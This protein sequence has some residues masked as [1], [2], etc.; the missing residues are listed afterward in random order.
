MLLFLMLVAKSSA[1]L[2][3]VLVAGSTGIENYRHQADLC[4]S[5]HLLVDRMAVDPSQVTVMMYDDVAWSPMNPLIGR[6][7]NE[8]DGDNVYEGCLVNHRKET[9]TVDNF[10]AVLNNLAA[11]GNGTKNL[12]V[13]FVDHGQPG[14]LMFPNGE[15]LSG[16]RLVESLHTISSRFANIVVYVEACFAGSVFENHKLPS[17]T[18]AV[19][20]A[21]AT[22]SSWGTFCPTP[23]HPDADAV[24]GIH[25]GTCLGDLFE[26]AWIKD[27]ETRIQE[28]SIRRSTLAH[29]INRVRETV[30]RKSHVVVYG[31]E[32][33]LNMNI[34]DFFPFQNQTVT[35]RN[36]IKIDTE[37]MI[38]TSRISKC[39]WVT[40]LCEAPDTYDTR[41]VVA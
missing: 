5:Y 15:Q 20:A 29:H 26:V 34:T 28:G 13:S 32:V 3:S 22:E 2:Y 9:V 30:N 36:G 12:F 10:L 14:S 35:P 39:N 17:N 11:S 41:T 23:K 38:E 7:F 27:I 40:G 37:L 31:N 1:T 16:N 8:P 6:L 25:I 33:M 4:H 18:V 21:N 19:T 24:N